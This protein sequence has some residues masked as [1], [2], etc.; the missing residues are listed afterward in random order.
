MRELLRDPLSHFLLG[1]LLIFLAFAAVRG[2]EAV[3]DGA[4]VIVVDRPTLLDFVQKRSRAFDPELAA[5]R[6]DALSDVELERLVEDYV[7]EEALHREAL[8]LALDRDDYVLRRRLVQ[9]LEFV[10]QGFAEAGTTLDEPE[11]VRF[12]EAHADDYYAEPSITFTHV[13]FDAEER[14]R[15]EARRRA[16]VK[17]DQLNRERV[18]FSD[19]PR[20]G[21]RFL[22]HVNYVERTPDYVESH[23]GREMGR[24][25]FGLEPDPGRWHGPFDSPYGSHLVL[26]SGRTPGRTPSLEE[27]RGRVEEDARRARVRER[28]EAAIAEIVARYRVRVDLDRSRVA[29]GAAA[30]DGGS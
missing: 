6:L 15:K 22:Y 11:L 5:R 16:E 13:F 2:L 29:P 21:D 1:G 19:A 8:A 18:P 25:V 26:V 12:F 30:P 23:F 9:K 24:A 27:I 7:R 17:L 20:H 14:G 4:D 10:A 28:S 3:S